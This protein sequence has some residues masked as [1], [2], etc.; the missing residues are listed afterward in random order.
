MPTFTESREGTPGLSKKA[1]VEE[2]GTGAQRGA[3][4]S[5]H[6]DPRTREP[7]GT[8]TELQTFAEEPLG[9]LAAS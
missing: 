6:T 4:T 3:R 1:L 8:E 7:C 9:A 5:P 2:P